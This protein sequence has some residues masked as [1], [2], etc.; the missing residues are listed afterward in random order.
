MTKE[1]EQILLRKIDSKLIKDIPESA[2]WHMQHKPYQGGGGT[3]G[4]SGSSEQADFGAILCD[5][6]G[7]KRSS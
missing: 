5:E 2:K 7:G 3:S 1:Q 4:D 6:G